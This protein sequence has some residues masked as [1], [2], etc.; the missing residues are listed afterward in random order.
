MASLLIRQLL[1]HG[2]QSCTLSLDKFSILVTFI[3]YNCVLF[4]ERKHDPILKEINVKKVQELTPKK[5]KLYEWGNRKKKQLHNIRRNRKSKEP[6]QKK[7]SSNSVSKSEDNTK[8]KTNF[9][10]SQLSL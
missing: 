1:P 6:L 7:L 5:R 9:L 2:Q 10:N 4:T 3:N 8:T